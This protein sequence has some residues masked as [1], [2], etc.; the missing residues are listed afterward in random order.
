LGIQHHGL[1]SALWMGGKGISKRQ[2]LC[3]RHFRVGTY[4]LVAQ[5]DHK[6]KASEGHQYPAELHHSGTYWRPPQSCLT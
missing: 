1:V 4:Q 3:W 5:N 2:S 6:S